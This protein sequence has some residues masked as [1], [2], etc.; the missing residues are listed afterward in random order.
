[1]LEIMSALTCQLTGIDPV[2]HSQ[3]CLGVD[4]KTGKIGFVKNGGGAIGIMGSFIAVTF[5]PPI[6]TV[7]YVNYIS[8]NFGLTKQAYAQ[9]QGIGFQ[10][11]QPLMKIW[12]AFRNITYL[13]FVLVFV[14]IGLAIMLRVRIDPRTVMTIQNQIPK[15]IIGIL[16]VT[17]SFAIAGFLIDFMWV[18]VYL[19]INIISNASGINLSTIPNNLLENPIGF[20]NNIPF[21]GVGPTGILGIVITTSDA[22]KTIVTSLFGPAVITVHPAQQQQQNITQT[23]I[24]NILVFTVPPAAGIKA[25]FDLWGIA[26]DV[27]LKSL[28]VVIG[29]I[30]GILA[31]LIIA[32]AILWALFRLWFQLI[33]A[34][35]GILFDVILAPLWI[36]AGVLPG[37]NVGFGTWIRDIVGNLA[38]FPTAIAMFLF[39]MVFINAFGE[40]QNTGDF[41]APLIG[42]PGSIN[43]I[44][45]L[46]GLGIILYTPKVVD[47]VRN[48]I[49]APKIDLTP[50]SQAIGVG[51]A[52][53][54]RAISG[55]TN[56]AVGV[57]Y[58]EYQDAAGVKQVRMVGGTGNISRFLRSFGFAR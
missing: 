57:H 41:V 31:F 50:I 7:D 29:G 30:A 1:M 23:I 24:D 42:N 18:F 32:I 17:F 4:Q 52:T 33:V 54:G 10:G 53:P 51:T 37:V 55:I 14:L 49:K 9:Q 58:E 13:L 6:H 22:V 40:T 16:L 34:Y 15:I 27:I 28:G 26:G 21:A 48:A 11:I 36:V 2:N 39:G 56:A 44:G 19:V 45:A 46:I 25:I 47:M 43:L 8:K 5:T 38:A 35:I 12:I 3:S 20:T